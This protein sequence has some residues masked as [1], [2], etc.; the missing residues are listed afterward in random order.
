MTTLCRD[1]LTHVDFDATACPEC[2]ASRLVSHDELPTLTIAHI[3]C[4]AFYA[5]VE[6][7]D[8]PAL[9]DQPVIV[10]HAGGRGVVTTACYVAR[11]YGPRSAMPMFKALKL[12]PQ[13]VVIAPDMA[14]YK[15]VS[16]QIRA[17]FREATPVIEPVSLDEAYLDLAGDIRRAPRMP[18]VVLAN[19]AARVEKEV[20]LTV[21]IGLSYNKFL[22]KLASDLDK[23][24]GYAVIGRAEAE[25]FLATLPV[26]RIAGIGA[27]TTRRMADQGIETVADLQAL[28]EQELVARYGRF[29]RRLASLVRGEDNRAV[30]PH[31]QAKSISAE[32]TFARDLRDREELSATLRR[33]CD[34]VAAR[35]QGSGLAGQTVVLK[36][37]TSDF[38][39]LTRNRRL[40]SP[41]QKAEVIYGHANLALRDETDGRAFRLIGVGVGDLGPPEQADPPDLFGQ[42]G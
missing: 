7:R 18:A 30:T 12:C 28:S 40:A 42:A 6:K 25:D 38:Q 22:A 16:A 8:N 15:R 4:D 29:G 27:A 10:G 11:R 1:C 36:L 13:A 9:C 23:P 37:K 17:I 20:G 33:L 2:G 21:S 5:A 14:K 24:R 32:T 39:I 34:R 26:R 31:R 41:T 19:I 35:L 3:D